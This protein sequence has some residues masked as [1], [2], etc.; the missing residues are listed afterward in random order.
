[1]VGI[2]QNQREIWNI[3]IVQKYVVDIEIKNYV[4]LGITF[5]F[6]FGSV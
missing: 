3:L 5:F 1:M 2:Y 4:P 6:S